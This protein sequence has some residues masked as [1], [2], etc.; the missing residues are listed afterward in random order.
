MHLRQGGPQYPVWSNLFFIL[1]L[2]SQKNI[3]KILKL[4]TDPLGVIQMREA[5]RHFL[6]SF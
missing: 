4:V 5:G 6:R 1:S 3:K 2:E